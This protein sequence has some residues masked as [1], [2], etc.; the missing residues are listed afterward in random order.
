V[1]RVRGVRFERRP[2][3]GRPGPPAGGVRLAAR[4]LLPAGRKAEH[5]AGWR[6]LVTSV[7][8]H[9]TEN[10]PPDDRE[11]GWLTLTR[12]TRQLAHHLGVIPLDRVLAPLPASRADARRE[13]EPLLDGLVLARPGAV[14]LP[15]PVAPGTARAVPQW[16]ETAR[17]LTFRGHV[18]KT[19]RQPAPD[20]VRVLTTFQEDGWPEA[21]DD[22]LSD[23]KIAQT[24]ESLNRRLNHIRFRLNGAGTGVIWEPI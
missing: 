9:Q 7:L 16:D 12:A 10:I 11:Y 2:G 21:I 6:G 15:R 20:Q 23:G 8:G 19:Y 4:R 18:C 17:R 22:P 24:V 13:I 5:C 14:A 1:G 3:T